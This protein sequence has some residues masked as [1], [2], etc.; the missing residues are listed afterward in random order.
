MDIIILN[1]GFVK[2]DKPIYDSKQ[3]NKGTSQ[4][5]TA[6]YRFL[7]E[8]SVDLTLDKQVCITFSDQYVLIIKNKDKGIQEFSESFGFLN[9][10][11]TTQV[12]EKIRVKIYRNARMK[13][14]NAVSTRTT[15]KKI[16]CDRVEINT[17][18]KTITAHICSF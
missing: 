18:D 16:Y 15:L 11:T 4:F 2:L 14:R 6:A 10:P 1:I 9:N 3:L 12:I 5:G 8:A 13:N 7:S 17:G